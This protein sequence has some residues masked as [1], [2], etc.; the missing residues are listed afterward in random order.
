MAN[1]FFVFSIQSF[2]PNPMPQNPSFVFLTGTCSNC[3]VALTVCSTLTK[4]FSGSVDP[5]LPAGAF[6]AS[7]SKY[8]QLCSCLAAMGTGTVQMQVSYKLTNNLFEVTD[9]TCSVVP[10]LAG[11]QQQ[12]SV[13]AANSGQIEQL[14]A[15]DLSGGVLTELR[16]L[17]GLVAE[18]LSVLRQDRMTPSAAPPSE[19]GLDRLQSDF[20]GLAHAMEHVEEDVG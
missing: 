20:T 17:K 16:G 9:I 15:N 2:L 4:F 7:T 13:I 14:L 3:L 8:S 19:L 6:G 18:M 12:L 11:I 1:P 10:A 5:N